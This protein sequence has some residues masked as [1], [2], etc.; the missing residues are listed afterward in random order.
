MKLELIFAGVVFGALPGLILLQSLS[1]LA[2]AFGTAMIG[3]ALLMLFLSFTKSNISQIPWVIFAL[4]TAE[5]LVD[6]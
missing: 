2:T 5:D 4:R 3:F 1:S 6:R